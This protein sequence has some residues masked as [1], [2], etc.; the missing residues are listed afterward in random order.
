MQQ[1]KTRLFWSNTPV[2]R[3]GHRQIG[4][5]QDVYIIA[6]AGVN[7]NG[8]IDLAIQLVE[9]AKRAGADAVKFQVFTADNL[10]ISNAPTATYQA[11]RGHGNQKQMLRQLELTREEFVDVFNYC[12]DVGIDFLATPFSIADLEFLLELGVSAIKIASPDIVNIPLLEKVIASNLP[13]IVSTGASVSEE[14]TQLVDLFTNNAAL[15][16]LILMHC[17]SSYPTK[18]SNA[19]LAVI[20][21]LARQFPLPV[22]FSDHTA[23]WITGALA[24]SAGA[25]VLEKHFTISRDMPGPDHSFSLE[26]S[27]LRQYILAAREAQHALGNPHRNLLECEKEVRNIARGSVVATIDISAG[28]IIT[29]A[30]VAVKR[31]AGGIE[32]VRIKEVIGSQT[33][34][35]IPADS[36]IDWQMLKPLSDE[37]IPTPALQKNNVAHQ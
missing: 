12:K 9:I 30:M 34:V 27:Q 31:P 4:P 33:L 22:G 3:I 17:I 37:H 11:E 23:E 25:T 10:V 14:I 29:P 16:R 36:Q 28:T 21:N 19:N 24:V 7:H 18:L 6:E 5:G 8:K 13:A 32:P 20:S 35:D 26:E 1:N 15:S 2:V